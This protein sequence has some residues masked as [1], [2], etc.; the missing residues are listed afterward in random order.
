V[1]REVFEQFR[2]VVEETSRDTSEHP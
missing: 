2:Q 1:A